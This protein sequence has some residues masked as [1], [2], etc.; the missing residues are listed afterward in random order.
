[1]LYEVITDQP[2]QVHEEDEDEAG[3]EQGDILLR[4]VPDDV[5]GQAHEE[6]QDELEQVAQGES[7]LRDDQVVGLLP[8]EGRN[9]FV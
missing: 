8:A 5:L 2:Q 3:G 1:M 9:N 4:L 7:G 6:A